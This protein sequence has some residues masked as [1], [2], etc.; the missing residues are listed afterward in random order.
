MEE[1]DRLDVGEVR[2][3]TMEEF[4]G[5]DVGDSLDDPMSTYSALKRMEKPGAVVAN[6]VRQKRDREELVEEEESEPVSSEKISCSTLDY[7]R[8]QCSLCPVKPRMAS[9]RNHIKKL[10]HINIKEYREI[11]G[12]LVPL[13]VMLILLNFLFMFIFSFF[14]FILLF[15]VVHH[16]CGLCGSLLLLD[17]DTIASHLKVMEGGHGGTMSY[18]DYNSS[19]MTSL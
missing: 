10:H 19:F 8:M 12:L 3:I 16:Q 11:Y 14:C 1:Y 9:M 5:L 17:S 13:Q 2:S 6:L 7:V 4:D 18:K 15:Q